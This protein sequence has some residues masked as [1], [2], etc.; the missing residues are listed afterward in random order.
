MPN[1]LSFVVVE[2]S[3][4]IKEVSVKEINF[5][6]IY[7]KCG[8][9]KGDDFE[10]RTTWE[11]IEVG[12]TKHTIQLWARSEGKANTEN[13]YDFPPPVDSN[14]FYGNCALVEIKNDKYTSLTKDA[15]LKMY[16]VLFGGFEDIENDKDDEE[17]DELENIK[18]E[19]KTTKGEYLKDGFV[20]DSDVSEDHVSGDTE[21]ENEGLDECTDETSEPQDLIEELEI[22]LSDGSELEE[23]EYEYSD[24]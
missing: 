18:K 23:E 4:T 24:D 12:K 20:V 5:E 14:L 15:W 1:K 6:E 13:K 7:K 11:D 10:C 17:S 8:F 3:G 2:K 19:M 21:E 16:E 9:R 22:M